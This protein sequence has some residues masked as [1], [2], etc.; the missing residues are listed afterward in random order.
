MD[1]QS[2]TGTPAGLFR[3]LAA[4]CY[5][6]LLLVALPMMLMMSAPLT[7]VALAVVPLIVLFSFVF[8]TV[9]HKAF[10]SRL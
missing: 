9:H 6:L 5:D 1:G 3:R 2:T 10:I 4:M 7:P 8:F